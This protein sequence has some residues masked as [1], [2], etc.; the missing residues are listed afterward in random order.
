MTLIDSKLSGDLVLILTLIIAV[1]YLLYLSIRKFLKFIPRYPPAIPAPHPAFADCI[2][3]ILQLCSN[4]QVVWITAWPIVTS[5]KCLLPNWNWFASVNLQGNAM[6]K[7]SLFEVLHFSIP[8]LCF[9][10]FPLP[11]FVFGANSHALPKTLLKRWK[12]GP[13]VNSAFPSPLYSLLSG[14]HPLSI[15]VLE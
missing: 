11:T 12:F 1:A 6:G 5:V 10:Q 14:F 15:E 9:R 7:Q 4:K 8:V 3:H 13:P 2:A